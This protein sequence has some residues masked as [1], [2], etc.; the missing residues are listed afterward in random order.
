MSN[1]KPIRKSRVTTSAGRN[2][3]TNGERQ[4]TAQIKEWLAQIEASR[5][6]AQSDLTEIERLKMETRALLSRMQAA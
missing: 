5:Q 1:T 2:T 4:Q 3:K 6:R